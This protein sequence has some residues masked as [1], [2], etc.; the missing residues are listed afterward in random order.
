MFGCLGYGNYKPIPCTYIITY[1][2][3]I[4]AMEHEPFNDLFPMGISI[5]ISPG[6]TS[7]VVKFV[8]NGIVKGSLVEKLPI[9]E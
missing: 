4:I 1:P 8:L 5:A 7:T 2:L 6:S 3:V 9:Y